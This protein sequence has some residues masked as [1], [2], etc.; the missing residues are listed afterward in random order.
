VFRTVA[1]V[2]GDPIEIGIEAEIGLV[3]S[4]LDGLHDLTEQ[5][6]AQALQE[7]AKFT[8]FIESTG[9]P[10]LEAVSTDLALEFIEQAIVDRSGRWAEPSPSKL[11]ARRGAIRLLY[12]A[13]FELRLVTRDPTS[14]IKLPPRDLGDVRPLADD[15]IL[16]GRQWARL[17]L[18]STRHAAA[19]ALAEASAT[20]TELAS[21]T[22]EDVDLA[23]GQVWL[24]GNARKRESR[25][26]ELTPWGVEQVAL[27]LEAIDIDPDVSLDP[28]R[29][30]LTGATASRNARQASTNSL[31]ADVLRFAGLAGEPG[32]KP[33]SVAAWAGRKVYDETLRFDL[34]ARTLGVRSLDAAARHI[35][36]AW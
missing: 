2:L 34:A 32:I 11:H 26:G 23:S 7:L 22:I 12:G 4:H 10:R 8:R 21:V 13:A 28:Q 30:L 1:A 14:F 17:T 5:S 16:L 24:H 27:H 6:W 20:N 29:L 31:I 3:G 15:E 35:Q 36:V 25:W 18:A 19:W 9:V 33:A